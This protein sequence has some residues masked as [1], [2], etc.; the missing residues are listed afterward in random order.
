MP[1]TKQEHERSLED[2]AVCELLKIRDF[3]DRVM[4]RTDGCYV[5]GF[6][7]AGAMTYFGDDDE[8]NEAKG[9]LESLLRAMPEQSMRLQFRYEVV[10]SLN[11]LLEQ[12]REDM[13]SENPDVQALDEQRTAIWREKEQEGAYLSRI[14]AVYLIWDPIKHKR[15]M[16]AGGA[17]MR[18]EDRRLAHGGFTLAVNKS[19]GKS[20]EEHE[21]TL[22]EFESII[23]GIES[24]MKTGGL[25][26]ERMTEDD[27]FLEIKRAMR[28]M[29]PDRKLLKAHPD[30]TEYI[31]SRKRATT[32]SI[33]GQT[34]SY[35][36]IDGLLWSF[37]SL[38]VPP[39]GTYLG[40]LRQLMTTGFPIV[41]S[42]QVS[43]PDQRVIL[44]KYKKKLRKMQAAQKDS[45]G[46][47]R[48]DVTAQVATHELIQIQQEL[49]ANSVKTAR[50]SMIVGIRTSAPAWSAG[51]YEKAERELANR[52]QQVLHIV[53]HMDGARGLSESLA[54]R[55][56]YLSTL[57]GLAEDDRRDLDLLTPHGADLLPLE[58]PWSGTTRSPLMLFETPYRQLLPFSPFDPALENAN[59]IIA[60]TSG[61]GK[62]VLVGKMLLTCARQDVQVSI[63]ERGDSYYHAATSMG[64]QMITMSL[65][66]RQT[67]NPF[68]LKPGQTEPSN[69]HLSFLKNLTRF[70]IGDSGEGDTDLLDNL[71]MNAIRKTYARAQMRMDNPIPLY[72]DLFDELQN[73]YDE[74]KNPR[75]NEMARIA[76]AKLRAWVN[77]GMYARLFDAH[78]TIDMSSP[79]LYFNVEQLK[80]D[81][82]LEVAMSLL[83]AYTTTKRAEGKTNKRC[84]TVLDE[85]WALL[86][87]PS[88]A[89]VVVQLFRTARKRNACVWGISQAVE[90]FTGTPDKPNEFGGAILATTAI[91]MIGRQKGNFDVLR[92][93]VHLNETTLNRVKI[94]GM[95]EKGKKSEFLIVIGEKAETT[96]SLYIVPTP[97]E[98]WLL[99][100]YPRERW[101]RQ[102][103][104]STHSE[105]SLMESFGELAKRFP[106]GLSDLPE[107][108]EERS[109]E[110]NRLGTVGMYAPPSSDT[111][112]ESTKAV[113]AGSAM[114]EA[115][116]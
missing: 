76:A 17:P 59:A 22:A 86:Q 4:V 26:P 57:P 36:N 90:D 50:V 111:T 49:I 33:L 51:Q 114:Q 110:V 79:W 65:D 81:P 31:S 82:K 14:A 46:N 70:M 47:L 64:G 100:T 83:I 16:M 52:R 87:S 68:D 45:K 104:L 56:I 60:A 53:A 97:M 2:P 84:I 24:A 42:T 13:R 67:I 9:V 101:Y 43:I 116:V 78:T 115:L 112:H 3:L 6:R 77:N 1:K 19:I 92:H 106:N 88:L 73:Y 58:L 69:D 37:I 38:N 74:D 21:S 55:R 103:W 72:S 107:L 10:E 98:Y 66:S 35:I 30:E 28:P 39:D 91:K 40:I 34:E 11:G 113:T 75:V 63:V 71:I 23:A 15:A 41:I 12:Y 20:R 109:G 27:L 85:C 108:A 80:D 102:W 48:V 8:R 99:T 54:A 18:K 62:S 7:V 44:D 29:D 95:T 89:P 105:M 94:L 25:G 5:A 61:T 32:V 96:H 93:F